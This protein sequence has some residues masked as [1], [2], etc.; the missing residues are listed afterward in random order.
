MWP[1]KPTLV[2]HRENKIMKIILE[3][4]T[5]ERGLKKSE[6]GANISLSLNFEIVHP[7]RQKTSIL[8]AKMNW[9]LQQLC[10]VQ[11]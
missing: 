8:S 2:L 6:K 5:K 10:N 9:F 1:L 7:T 11:N 4:V 3:D